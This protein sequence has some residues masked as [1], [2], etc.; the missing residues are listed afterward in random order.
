M[1]GPP[2]RGG[3]KEENICGWVFVFNACYVPALV[4]VEAT[5]LVECIKIRKSPVAPFENNKS[6]K[7][8]QT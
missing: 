3:V 1:H 6:Y 2:N 8:T 4:L 7:K 5:Q